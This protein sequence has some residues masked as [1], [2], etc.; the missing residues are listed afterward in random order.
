MFNKHFHYLSF[1]W[2]M[3]EW[4]A[5]APRCRQ[6]YPSFWKNIVWAKRQLKM[7]ETLHLYLDWKGEHFPNVDTREIQIFAAALR[8]LAKNR[9]IKKRK[10]FRFRWWKRIHL[11]R[12][13]FSLF[14]HLTTLNSPFHYVTVTRIVFSLHILAF[15]NKIVHK[16]Y[17][18]WNF[19]VFF[20]KNLFFSCIQDGN[21]GE[22][23]SVLSLCKHNFLTTQIFH[24][25][26]TDGLR[27][28]T[29]HTTLLL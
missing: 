28:K 29:V 19:I 27:C 23:L 26:N 18:G 12:L 8:R 15:C 5:H 3:T 9:L 10:G 24:I 7:R 11:L 14:W 6:F 17:A 1:L 20:I 16:F 13:F 22:A 2:D 21:T 4:L 25:S